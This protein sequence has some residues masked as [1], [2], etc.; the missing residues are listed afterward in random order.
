MSSGFPLLRSSRL[1]S[2]LFLLGLLQLLDSGLQFLRCER[3]G[4]RVVSPSLPALDCRAEEHERAEP[5]AWLLMAGAIAVPWGIMA[6]LVR[7]R[8]RNAFRDQRRRI[9]RAN[10]EQGQEDQDQA[11]AGNAADAYGSAGNAAAAAGS[12]AG[13]PASACPGRPSDLSELV[14]QTLTE[15]FRTGCWYWFP[16]LILR[17]FALAGLNSLFWSER[18]RSSR[19]LAFALLHSLF[20]LASVLLR[21][22][23]LRAENRLELLGRTGLVLLA[24]YLGMLRPPIDTAEEATLMMLVLPPG[25]ILAAAVVIARAPGKRVK[26]MRAALCLDRE[27]GDG[28]DQIDPAVRGMQHQKRSPSNPNNQVESPEQQRSSSAAVVDPVS[29]SVSSLSIEMTTIPS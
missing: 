9:Q 28:K 5:L 21:P 11:R 27:Q 16:I 29:T 13:T 2:S 22:Y 1:L 4:A 23:R 26:R 20:G 17:Q 19:F 15:P 14:Y 24:A 10:Q 7:M 8:R 25:L 6:F 3:I 12:V 18:Y